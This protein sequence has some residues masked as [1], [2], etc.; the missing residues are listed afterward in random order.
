MFP[1]ETRLVK[2]SHSSLVLYSIFL[3]NKQNAFH[4]MAAGNYSTADISVID[5]LIENG[6]DV[7]R[8]DKVTSFFS[9]KDN[10]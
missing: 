9:S 5:L 3:Q 2:K 10:L 6:C 1:S 7:S 4:I 8:Q